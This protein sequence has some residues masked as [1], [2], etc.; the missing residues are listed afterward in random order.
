MTP[1]PQQHIVEM[2]A[3][4]THRTLPQQVVEET[5]KF[6]RALDVE[7]QVLCRDLRNEEEP[8]LWVEIRTHQSSLLIGTQGSTLRAVEHVLRLLLRPFTGSAIRIL[9]DVNAY[10]VRHMEALRRRARLAAERVRLTGRAVLLESMSPEDRRVVHLALAADGLV[11]TE[12][13]GQ[14]PDRRVMIRPR[15]PLAS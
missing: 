5:M 10:R 3:L 7:G 1:R 11:S 13:Q 15:D 2:E 14:G 6:L 9:V 12:S 4:T 8:H